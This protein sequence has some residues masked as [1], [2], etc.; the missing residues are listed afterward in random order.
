M[1]SESAEL[2]DLIYGSFK[3]YE[4][5][6]DRLFHVLSRA[7]PR[8]K[9]VLDVACGTGEHARLLAERHGLSVDGVDLDPTFVQI[10]Q[11]KVPAG[12]FVQGDM[13]NFDLG[14]RY[15]VVMCLFSSIG[16]VR[17]LDRLTRAIGCFRDHLEP[18]G[19]IVVEPWFPPGVMT[20]GYTS[21]DVGE[22]GGL[23]VVRRAR[24]EIDGRLSRLHFDY[25]ITRNGQTRHVSE[26]HELGLFTL[27]E[28]RGAFEG[29][30]LV[31]EYDPNGLTGRGL[32]V[33][34]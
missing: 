13:S 21:T 28:M 10:A 2:Y 26:I 18:G 19:V 30:G 27:D 17:T 9:T 6:T 34:R 25:D 22:S 31:V 29:N 23:R 15:D 11:R 20:Y 5:E 24:T 16:Y 14:R 8:L 1:Y 7:R 12:R 3:N 33:A 4:E 32:Y